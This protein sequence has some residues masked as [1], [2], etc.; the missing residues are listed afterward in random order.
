MSFRG[1]FLRFGLDV[2]N[3]ALKVLNPNGWIFPVV[4][5]SVAVR[6]KTSTGNLAAAD[7]GA[8][9]TNTGASGAIVLTLL[10]ASG[11]T[12]KFFRV[13]VTAAQ[14]VSLSPQSSDAIYLGGNGVDDKD[15]VIAGVIGNY[16]DVY[17]D[18]TNYHVVGYSGVLTKEA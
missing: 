11:N 9:I 3:N 15:L 10:A 7:F 5:P 13:Q 1:K 4:Y 16:A 18:G 8:N 6:A 12:G 17:C 2:V 14:Q